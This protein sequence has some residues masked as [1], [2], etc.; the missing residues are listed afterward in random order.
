MMWFLGE[1]PP[2]TGKAFTM[3]VDQIKSISFTLI[4]GSFLA[5]FV[6]TSILQ[7]KRIRIALDPT[8]P[9]PLVFEIMHM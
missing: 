5:Q 3:Q 6:D 7:V 1:K 8:R 4:D 9:D 2:R